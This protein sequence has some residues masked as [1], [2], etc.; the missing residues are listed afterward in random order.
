MSWEVMSAVGETIGGFGVILSLLYVA[1]QVRDNTHSNQSA[2]INA[3]TGQLMNLTLIDPAS[4]DSY[5]Q[6]LKG[7]HNLGDRDQLVFTHRIT[8][9]T[10]T[11]FNAYLQN[12]RGLIP[13]E[14]WDTFAG[15]IAS[16]QQHP[17]FREAWALI[18]PGFP[19]E[20]VAYVDASA[21]LQPA[22]DY[23][24]MSVE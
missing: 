3:L 5:H 8:A 15:D 22:V 1:R 13:A 11:W 17:G 7:L 21:Q 20:F 18:S 2:A 10:L 24:A 6:G 4:A 16:F 14:F 23:V 12:K 9:L 19:D